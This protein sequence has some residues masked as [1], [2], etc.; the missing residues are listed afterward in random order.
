MSAIVDEVVGRIHQDTST[1]KIFIDSANKC[2]EILWLG[3]VDY[4]DYQKTML[5]AK[6]LVD[7]EGYGHAI[8]NRLQLDEISPDSA[9]WLKKEFI[10]I[11]LKP[12]I[13]KLQKVATVESKSTFSRFY[14]NSLTLAT[15]VIYPNLSIKSF[16]GRDEALTWI[17]N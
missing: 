1:A 7:E 8:I 4:D 6:R 12:I 14:S 17:N 9:L 16:G 11:H 10:K 3:K 5:E 13:N 2:L 15:K